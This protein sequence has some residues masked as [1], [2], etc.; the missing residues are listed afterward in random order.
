[1]VVVH[2]AA[3]GAR[4]DA[5]RAAGGPRGLAEHPTHQHPDRAADRGARALGTAFIFKGIA[6]TGIDDI[7]AGAQVAEGTFY[8]YFPSREALLGALQQRFVDN[9]CGRLQDGMDRYRPDNHRPGSRCG[10]RL[11]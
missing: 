10:S 5:G 1:M 7:A 9:F 6:A 11:A 3:A 2:G 4:A 8:L